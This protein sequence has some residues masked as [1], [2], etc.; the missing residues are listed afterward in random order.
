[1]KTKLILFLLIVSGAYFSGI[2]AQVKQVS[3]IEE[4][5]IYVAG[6]GFIKITC[7]PKI[8]ELVGLLSPEL[9][10][11]KENTILANG[12]RIQVFMSNDGKTARKESSEKRTLIK[13]LFPE[14]A[15]YEDFVAPNWKLLAGDF[16]T[17]EEADVFKQK[18]LKAIPQLG[19]EMYVVQNK[20]NIS[21]RK[22]Y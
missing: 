7:D 1:M 8:K 13:G 12:F 16:L 10:E 2:Q 17:K 6:E 4:L 21:I 14:I 5:E 15:V 19:K 18:M 22:N 20:I 9:S 3:I 11:D